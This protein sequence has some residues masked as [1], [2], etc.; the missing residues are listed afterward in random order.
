MPA[1][2]I[3]AREVSVYARWLWNNGSLTCVN[4]RF[5]KSQAEDLFAIVPGLFFVLANEATS[6]HDVY[7]NS[8]SR[9]VQQ[10][11]GDEASSL[12][13]MAQVDVGQGVMPVSVYLPHSPIETKAVV[14]LMYPRSGM[15]GFPQR[16]ANDLA[17]HGLVTFVPDITHRIRDEVPFRDRKRLLQDEDILEDVGGLLTH[18]DNSEF[19]NLARFVLGHCMGG[20]NALLAA[21]AYAFSGA[22]VFYGGEMFE[23]WGGMINP[24]MRLQHIRCPVLGFFGGKDKNPS[25]TDVERIRQEL[26]RAQI[27]HRF[28]TYP[29]VGHAFQQNA[30]RT[31]EERA[32]AD[33]STT[34]M[35]EFLSRLSASRG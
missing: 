7:S 19:G 27:E 23:A 4:Y 22:I 17:L 35:L 13:A 20:R 16:I 18:I 30:E 29:E 14:I 1:Q 28:T 34:H 3:S 8:V 25:P 32:A 12:A 5:V 15:D 10:M 21:S 33:D 11:I 31:A 9:Q 26:L 6:P 2:I 24:F